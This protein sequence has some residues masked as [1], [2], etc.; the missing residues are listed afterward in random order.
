MRANELYLYTA[1][2]TVSSCSLCC[3][4]LRLPPQVDRVR[5]LLLGLAIL[6]RKG[7]VVQARRNQIAIR[8]G[9]ALRSAIPPVLLTK[10]DTYANK[11]VKLIGDV[12]LEFAAHRWTTVIAEMQCVCV[13]RRF[14][15]T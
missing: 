2:L 1:A 8:I 14:Q 3:P 4:V 10:L 5:D 7:N 12:P 13:S 11:G 6:S 9:A 15:A